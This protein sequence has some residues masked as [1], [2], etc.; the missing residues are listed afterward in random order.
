MWCDEMNRMVGRRRVK[1][2]QASWRP[3]RA[4]VSK[5]L[6]VAPD[7]GR[8]VVVA[9]DSFAPV[10]RPGDWGPYAESFLRLNDQALRLLCVSPEVTG[11][12]SGVVVR[13]VPGECA[14][15]VPLRSCVNG[16]VAGG[17]LVKPRFGWSGVGHVLQETGWHASPQLPEMPMVPGSA[18]SVPPWVLAG[19]VLSRLEGLLK[20]LS[21]GYRHIEETTSKPR[22]RILWSDY[23][24]K[25]LTCGQWHQLP[26]R[27][28][29]LDTDPVLRQYIRWTLE[30]LKRDLSLVGVGDPVALS[31]VGVACRLLDS[32]S[33]VTPLMPRRDELDRRLGGSRLANQWLRYGIE[34][35]AWVVDERGLGG[36]SERDGLS[37]VLPL[38]RLWEDYVESVYRREVA[39]YGGVLKVGRLR[40]TVFPLEWSDATHRTLGHLMPDMVIH[41]GNSVQIVDAKYKAHLSEIDESDWRQFSSEL[42]DAHRADLHQVLAYAS[43]FEADEVTATLVYPLRYSTYTSLREQGRDRSRAELL[44]GG[45]TVR[46]ELRGLPFGQ[47]GMH[48][49]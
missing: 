11:G 3:S 42:R 34:A 30:R 2:V 8:P 41:K 45:R 27:Y 15:A 37:W 4:P 35:I 18:R 21:P 44:H 39:Q 29:D 47:L 14:G 48:R 9:P 26:C 19:P 7:H 40:E 10:Q 36:G 13:F 46:V 6:L 43:L 17:L 23:V 20:T 12:A 1:R 25:S 49:G 5:P 32:L 28:P 33:D 38:A 24:S 16:K 31:L 22:G